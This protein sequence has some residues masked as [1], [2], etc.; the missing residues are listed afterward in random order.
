MKVNDQQI[1]VLSKLRQKAWRQ[2]LAAKLTANTTA[3][4]GNIFLRK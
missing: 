3:T 4:D 2:K 1:S